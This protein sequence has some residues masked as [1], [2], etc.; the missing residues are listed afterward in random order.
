MPTRDTNWPNGTPCWIDYG[1]ADV[2]GAKA[3]Y[4][5]VLG[6]TYEGGDDPEYGGYMTCQTKGLAAAGM[7]PQQDPNDPPKWM[8]YFASD[9]LDATAKRITEAGGTL[10]FEPMD[11]GPMGRMVIARDP[12]GHPFGVWQGA[13]HTGARIYNE[14][15]SLVWNEAAVDDPDAERTFYGAVFGFTFDEMP[16]SGGYTTFKTDG[17]PLGGLTR[18]EPGSPKGW[19]TCF[20]V[21]SADA[22]VAAVEKGGGKVTTPAQDM[23]FGRFAVLEDAWG[24]PFSVMQELPG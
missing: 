17:G 18:H 5:E 22:A 8:T 9:D 6:W 11:V 15:G 21:T 12:E 2:E 1:A 10:L 23:P 13:E 14:P 7:A 16:D 4:A 20:S 3:F 24:A 19:T